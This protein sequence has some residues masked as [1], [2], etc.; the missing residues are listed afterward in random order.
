VRIPGLGKVWLVVRC[1]DEALTSR[2]MGL[3]T[4]RVDWS[5]AKSMSLYLQRW[6]TA[7][8]NPDSKGHL[9]D[10]SRESRGGF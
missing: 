5:A 2:S 8:F 1:E 3:V 10:R 4:N 7:P 9:C 6:P